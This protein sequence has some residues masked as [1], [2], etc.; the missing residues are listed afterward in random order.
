MSTN[1]TY[2]AAMAYTTDFD[3]MSVAMASSSISPFSDALDIGNGTNGTMDDFMQCQPPDRSTVA[4]LM[5]FI[6]YAVVCII[7]VTG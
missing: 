5:F 2:L 3:G 1:A 7:G 4:N 6:L